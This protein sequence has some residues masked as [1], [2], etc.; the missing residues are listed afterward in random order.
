M[1]LKVFFTYCSHE[2][3]HPE[4]A[5]EA[6]EFRPCSHVQRSFKSWLD[7]IRASADRSG[8]PD[9][10]HGWEGQQ[11]CTVQCL[12][13]NCCSAHIAVGIGTELCVNSFDNRY[14]LLCRPPHPHCSVTSSPTHCCG[15]DKELGQAE[16]LRCHL[17]QG[18]KMF[19]C[20]VSP[21]VTCMAVFG[22]PC[23]QCH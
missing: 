21:G 18:G 22:D 3:L 14:I 2:L 7:D 1:D 16:P 11:P 20:R 9:F 8:S 12:T 6:E 19:M 13:L 10:K 4:A 15:R 17:I 23:K 5:P